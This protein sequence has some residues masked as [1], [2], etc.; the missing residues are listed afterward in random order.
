MHEA[1][2]DGGA[3]S[4]WG[5][6]RSRQFHDLERHDYGDS[7]AFCGTRDALKS[8][9]LIPAGTLF[10]DECDA[11]RGVR[12]RSETGRRFTLAK[13]WGPV[14]TFRLTVYAN[15]EEK[16]QMNHAARVA[17]EVEALDK[18]LESI[19][20]TEHEFRDSARRLLLAFWRGAI[21]DNGLGQDV[22][23][24]S[25]EVLESMQEHF[26]EIQSL[27]SYGPVVR[28]TGALN[29]LKARKAAL[30]NEQLQSWIATLRA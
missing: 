4:D 14:G 1:T 2:K 22:W 23:A 16:R 6:V 11:R 30:Q 3:L 21:R 18:S 5:Q 24:Y 25:P 28:K 9:G 15:P 29:A 8:A 12:W 26:D 20:I 13:G 19:D 10:P 27:L 17:R 7:I